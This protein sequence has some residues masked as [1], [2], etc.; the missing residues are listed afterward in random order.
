[1]WNAQNESSPL[2]F[3]SPKLELM[4]VCKPTSARRWFR[5]IRYIYVCN[6]QFPIFCFSFYCWLW[7]LH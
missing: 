1:L 3:I 2:L 7:S 6:V 5:V 4:I